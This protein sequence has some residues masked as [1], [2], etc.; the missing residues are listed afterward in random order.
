MNA[1]LRAILTTTVAATFFGSLHAADTKAAADVGT[2][3]LK[4]KSSFSL[5]TDRRAPF[6]PIGWVKRA[7]EA[8]SEITTQAPKA[9][10]DE[11][12]FAVTSIMLGNPSLAVVN[13]RA[14]SEGEF[15]RLP[16]GSAP[17]KVCVQQIS[18]GTVSLN[19][20]RQIIVVNLKR[21][22]LAARRAEQL[23]DAEN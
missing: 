4:K 2:Y 10:L 1:S 15:I 12:A 17:I 19:Y 8:R 18:D 14:Y 21:Q 22:E 13:G 3:E 16:K 9:K 6:W 11:S 7:D 20:D 5:A 23:L